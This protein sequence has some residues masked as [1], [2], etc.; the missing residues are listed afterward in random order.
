[1]KK[2]HPGSRR[3]AMHMNTSPTHGPV[4]PIN[5]HSAR[6]DYTLPLRSQALGHFREAWEWTDITSYPIRTKEVQKGH[7][8]SMGIFHLSPQLLYL[9]T[10]L[11]LCNL[12]RNIWSC[13][14]LIKK[15]CKRCL[16]V[17]SFLI[18]Y[19]SLDCD[20]SFEKL[21][22]LTTLTR[23]TPT[24]RACKTSQMWG[25]YIKK[26][27]YWCNE[28]IYNYWYNSQTGHVNPNSLGGSFWENGGA[29]G[30]HS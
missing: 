15:H 23:P 18:I 3:H 25:Q 26:V 13:W 21:C 5:Q 29:L 22:T 7:V 4:P 14:N 20:T 16:N 10:S 19:V 27:A 6:T 1:M 8:I 24:G 12:T 17:T 9:S 28:V 11:P 30:T 2:C